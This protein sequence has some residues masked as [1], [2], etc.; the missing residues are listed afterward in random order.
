MGRLAKGR[1]PT[2][3]WDDAPFFQDSRRSRKSGPLCGIYVLPMFKI[4]AD[5]DYLCN[6]LK[7]NHFNSA[8]TPC[9]KCKADRAQ[10]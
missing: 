1:W 4:A 9:F 5:L 6:Y 10:H 2:R 7:L 3:D 8:A